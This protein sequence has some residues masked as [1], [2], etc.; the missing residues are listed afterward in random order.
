MHKI[1]GKTGVFASSLLV[2]V[3]SVFIYSPTNSSNATST[4][5]DVKVNIGSSLAVSLSTD[6]VAMEGRPGDLIISDPIRVYA[7]TNNERG[8]EVRMTDADEDTYMRHT[9]V[10]AYIRNAFDSILDEAISSGAESDETAAE[11]YIASKYAVDGVLDAAELNRVE[12]LG[13]NEW[14]VIDNL[15]AMAYNIGG[16]HVKQLPKS[17]SHGVFVIWSKKLI[18]S[19]ILGNI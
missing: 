7:S 1:L 10:D 9:E 18:L 3:L 13:D 14:G 4:A 16:D 11:E 19:M 12:K 5:A 6:K 15:A 2:T 8:M 17:T